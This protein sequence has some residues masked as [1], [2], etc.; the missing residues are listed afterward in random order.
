MSL[1]DSAFES[2]PESAVAP[3]SRHAVTFI[4][5]TVLLDMIGFGIIIPVLP[6]LIGDVGHVGLGP[7]SVIGA[8]QCWKIL[9][10]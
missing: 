10:S 7:A 8:R 1:P 3:V 6:A 2:A 4:L 9:P 5:I